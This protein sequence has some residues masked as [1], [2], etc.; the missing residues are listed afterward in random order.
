MPTPQPDETRQKFISR[1]IPQVL[2]EGT[3]DDGLQAA[4]VCHSF[5]RKNKR[6]EADSV[7]KTGEK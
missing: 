2:D 1:C 3:A 7:D 4:A 5:W 6:G